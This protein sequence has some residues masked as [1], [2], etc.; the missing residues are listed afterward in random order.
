VSVAA[1]TLA[2]VAVLD[3][4]GESRRLGELWR[5]RPAVIVWLRH[6]GCLFCKQQAG[7]FAA[8]RRRI[9][10][11]G[12]QL[13]FVGSG[14]VEHARDFRDNHVP[15][16][17]VFTDPGGDSYRAIG[18]RT[19]WRSVAN[20]HSLRAAAAAAARGHRQSATQGRADQQ[21]GVLVITP[22]GG[23]AYEY[24]SRHAGDHPPVGEVL[25]ALA[26]AGAANLPSGRA[27]RI[28]P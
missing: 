21:G 25:E 3:P 28:R 10:R 7:E 5:E 26:R 8:S 2:A 24:V 12:A 17:H 14:S 1:E 13:W 18:A 22:G 9:E 19:G 27:A 20:A 6:F 11:L 15:R 4:D 16:C 23:L